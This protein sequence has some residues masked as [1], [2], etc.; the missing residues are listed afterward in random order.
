MTTELRPQSLGE[1][2]DSSLS[3]YRKHFAIFTGITA[4]PVATY[5]FLFF[6]A[7]VSSRGLI[8][9]WAH[10]VPSITAILVF[11][12]L[13]YLV[14]PMLLGLS[15]AA[16]TRAI[17]ALYLDQ[18]F[19]IAR[20]YRD[21]R[22]HG[23]RSA[24][25]KLAEVLYTWTPA[26]VL[27]AGFFGIAGLIPP[28]FGGIGRSGAGSALGWTLISLA[29][30]LGLWMRVRYSLCVNASISENL[31]VHAALKRSVALTLKGRGRILIAVLL[32]MALYYALRYP[33]QM[34]S[35]RWPSRGGI[36]AIFSPHNML[37]WLCAFIVAT[38]LHSFWNIAI[39]LFYYDERIRKEGFDIQF[40]MDRASLTQT[41]EADVMPNAG[42]ASIAPGE[43]LG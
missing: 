28:A 41:E 39:T 29:V 21:V 22:P 10:N 1:I 13:S 7:T 4:F 19:G 43:V 5:Y 18:K 2:L 3:L 14:Y 37:E 27:Y 23:L 34:L 6:I 15:S 32:Y 11:D 8:K 16:T 30:V 35:P 26:V 25:V 33:I 17:Y 20:S 36:A 40:M 12:A 31:K 24:A 42:L 38:L 9:A